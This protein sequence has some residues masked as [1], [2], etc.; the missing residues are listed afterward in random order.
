MAEA[1]DWGKPKNQAA[2]ALL[3]HT[4]LEDGHD[5]DG[6]FIG[7][8]PLCDPQHEREGSAQINFV[9]GVFRCSSYCC[10]KGKRGASIVNVVKMM[11]E[12]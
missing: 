9:R 7:W 12:A 1:V 6:W 2:A 3:P 11:E 8:C 5:G 4:S 10:H